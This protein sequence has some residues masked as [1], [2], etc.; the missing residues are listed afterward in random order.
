MSKPIPGP[1]TLSTT[2][3]Y[4]QNPAKYNRTVLA[5]APFVATG[6]NANCVGFYQS[7]SAAATVTLVN[8]GSFT[9]PAAAASTP[10]AIYEMGVVSVTAGSVYLLFNS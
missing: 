9:T 2:Y 5:T 10:A 3:T 8:G 4:H 6:S 7:G 1:Y